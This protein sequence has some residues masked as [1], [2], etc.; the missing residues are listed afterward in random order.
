MRVTNEDIKRKID[1]LKNIFNCEIDKNDTK[2]IFNKNIILEFKNKSEMNNFLYN[3][4]KLYKN[5]ILDGV[6]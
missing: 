3:I 2:I 6:K 4:I 5:N 1:Y